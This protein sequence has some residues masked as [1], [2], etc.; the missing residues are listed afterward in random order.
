MFALTKFQISEK[1]VCFGLLS[2]P[3]DAEVFTYPDMVVYA[4]GVQE[5]EPFAS[6]KLSVS[7]QV[8]DAVLTCKRDEPL[9][10]FHSLFCVGVATLVHHLEDYRKGHSFVDYAESEDVDVTDGVNVVVNYLK[11][12]KF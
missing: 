10:E 5:S 7:H 9:D 6:N 11:V 4:S 12:T 3:D 8:S 1:P 2:V